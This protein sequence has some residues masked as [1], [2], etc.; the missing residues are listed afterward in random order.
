MCPQHVM[1][2]QTA[3]TLVYLLLMCYLML[4][5]LRTPFPPTPIKNAGPGA[6]VGSLN[7]A[8]SSQ[9]ATAPHCTNRY[10]CSS[11]LSTVQRATSICI[12]PQLFFLCADLRTEAT[13]Q[14]A[15]LVVPSKAAKITLRVI[16][17]QSRRAL[18]LRDKDRCQRMHCHD[19]CK[20]NAGTC[21]CTVGGGTCTDGRR[22][23]SIHSSRTGGQGLPGQ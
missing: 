1:S 16:H 20:T 15:V 4:H 10:Y 17:A 14:N 19:T 18:H 7:E 12:C 23:Q 21:L 13:R 11:F 6:V 3:V 22:P 8:D 9:N 5:C 2:S